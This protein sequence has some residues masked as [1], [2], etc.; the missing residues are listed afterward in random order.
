MLH[1]EG[2]MTRSGGRLD[3]QRHGLPFDSESV[4]EVGS[5]S[6]SP[7]CLGLVA[8]FRNVRPSLDQR[9]IAALLAG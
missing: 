4:L 6:G 2:T 7:R 8:A 3:V 1:R 9:R 5:G